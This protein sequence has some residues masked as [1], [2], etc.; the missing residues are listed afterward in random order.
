MLTKEQLIDIIEKTRKYYKDRH[1][2]Y[3]DNKLNMSDKEY[4]N[5]VVSDVIGDLDRIAE[6]IY[7]NLETKSE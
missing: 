2:D 3:K 5:M 1:Q 7:I 4:A 6:L